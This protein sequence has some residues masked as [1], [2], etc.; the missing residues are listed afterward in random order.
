MVTIQ[1]GGHSARHALTSVPIALAA[2]ILVSLAAC[3]EPER[4]GGPHAMHGWDAVNP[5]AAVNQD[6]AALRSATAPY[7]NFAKAKALG[8]STELTDCWSDPTQGA[9]G[10]HYADPSLIDGRVELEKPEL[11]MYEPHD[12]GELRFVGV[13][14]IVPIAAWTG[15]SRPRLFGVEFKRNDALGLYTLH[16]WVGR[17]NPSGILADWNPKVSCG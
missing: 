15:A 14:Y 16:A 7:H 4:S 3:D 13:E 8:Y 10:F 5:S 1:L 11:L 9:M 12:S 17:H 2:A 6:L